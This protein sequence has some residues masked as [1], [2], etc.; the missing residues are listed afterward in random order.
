M[1]C[2]PLPLL[3]PFPD[4]DWTSRFSET[5]SYSGYSEYYADEDHS[6]FCWK[7]YLDHPVS[8]P[9]AVMN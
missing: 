8:A 9:N 3:N 2:S 6:H 1:L 7:M 5:Q 4:T